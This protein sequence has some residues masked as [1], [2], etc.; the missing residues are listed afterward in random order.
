MLHYCK[1]LALCALFMQ[2]CQPQVIVY[3]PQVEIR[4]TPDL[5]GA[6][7]L[8]SDDS[9]AA[10]AVVAYRKPYYYAVTA[11][12]VVRGADW[13][14][15]DGQRAEVEAMSIDA[16]VALLKFKSFKTYTVYPLGRPELGQACWLIGWPWPGRIVNRGWISRLDGASLWHNAG[17]ASG[18]SGGPIL[19]AKG[20]LLGIVTSYLTER[21]IGWIL[22]SRN[23][24]DTVGRAVSAREIEHLMSLIPTDK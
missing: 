16:D 23:V 11:R 13:L 1:I 19:S 8:V 6:I 5:N 2:G 24:Y 10:C 21:D 20:E 18:C 7:R 3:T 15:V 9:Y 17:G 12:H 14:M 4:H 22:P